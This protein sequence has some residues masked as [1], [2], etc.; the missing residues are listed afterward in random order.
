MAQSLGSLYVELKAE[1]AGF[2]TGMSK[3]SFE[4]KRAAKDIQ[5][6]FNRIGSAVQESL[7]K[8]GPFGEA[9]SGLGSAAGSLFE[10][11]S[12]ASGGLAIATGAI[13]GFGAA[14]VAAAGSVGAMAIAGADLVEH[15]S[16]LSQETGIS[17]SDLQ[18]F[19]AVGASVG[20]SLD[21]MVAGTRKFDQA[22]AGS[23]KNANVTKTILKEL[24]VTS[25]DPKEAL[26]ELADAFQQMPNGV[27]KSNDAVALFGKAGRELI[28]NLNRGRE[29]VAEMSAAIDQSGQRINSEAITATENYRI[30]TAKLGVAWDGFKI[31]MVSSVLPTLT[32]L[33]GGLK[34]STKGVQDFITATLAKPGDAFLEILRGTSFGSIASTIIG[35]KAPAPPKPP[36]ESSDEAR[37]NQIAE[38]HY[39]IL[40]AG[41]AAVLK[42]EQTRAQI[43]YDSQNNRFKEAEA[44][45]SEIPALEKAVELEKQ[46]AA[47]AQHN[48]DIKERIAQLADA[49][50]ARVDRG[51][52][53]SARALQR[54]LPI[55]P[56]AGAPDVESAPTGDLISSVVGT[57]SAKAIAA[58][59]SGKAQ[60]DDFYE[61]WKSMQ[62]GNEASVNAD[63]DK[64]LTDFKELLDEQAISQQQFNAI[65]QAL[66]GERQQGLKQI[67]QDLGT[68]S[69][70]DSFKDMFDGIADNGKD[71]AR[72][73][74]ADLG[75]ALDG[76]N[77]Q[78]AKFIA[79][80]KG[81]NFKKL[82]QGLEENLTSS[83]LKKGESS[84]FGA[85]GFGKK[86]GESATSPLFVSIVPGLGG[87]T[88]G[89]TG[90]A[91]GIA[92]MFSGTGAGGFLG[93]LFS[94]I[95]FLE[96]GGDV[97]PGKLHVVGEDGPEWFVPNSSGRVAPSLKMSNGPA[98]VSLSFHVHGVTDSDSFKRSEAQTF[99]SLQQQLAIA[100][101]RS[102]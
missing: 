100:S 88:T 17:V 11:L 43:E 14:A 12:G 26:L 76:L 69:F 33:I 20:V 97:T 89:A 86:R 71:L 27:N 50:P 60:L 30:A 73:L 59:G 51:A 9:I 6:G 4:A 53:R 84:I 64:Q 99:S 35:P 8:L 95:P 41:G 78:L 36:S 46:A 57:G 80:G 92:S 81:L 90:G 3:A 44:L 72:S 37:Q 1:T 19:Q 49:G 15:I 21:E 5:E 40:A 70:K 45:Q 28:P 82:G 25:R 62:L 24:G 87:A 16:N 31:T 96:G 48:L 68:S 83:I 38:E 65:S 56:T 61:H 18:D 79:T 54:F 66:E 94:K 2:V 32:N 77:Q 67:R 102:R 23:G 55:D 58:F 10:G 39:R 74:T 47:I 85:L 7:G 22:I 75:Q 93:S 101:S 52:P 34:D 13:A 91:G 98:P 42:L 63:Y 29:G